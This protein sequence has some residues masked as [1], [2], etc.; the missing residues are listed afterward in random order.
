M[1]LFVQ[2]LRDCYKDLTIC[3]QEVLKG[4]ERVLKELEI[5]GRV[6]T[7]KLDQNTE[8]NPC[9]LRT[10]AVIQTHVKDH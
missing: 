4:T 6:K 10:I 5:G 9:D 1:V 8:K 7:I 2:S 3:K